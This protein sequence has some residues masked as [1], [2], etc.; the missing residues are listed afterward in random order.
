[1]SEAAK[2]QQGRGAAPTLTPIQGGKNGGGGSGSISRAQRAAVV[3]AMLGENAARPIV[4]KLDDQA[5]AQVS[6]ALETVQYLAREELAEIVIDFLQHLRA[7]SGSFRGG[8]DRA[9]AIVSG[10]LDDQRFGLIFGESPQETAGEDRN[11]TWVQLERQDPKKTAAYLNGLTPNLIALILRK[12]DVSVSSEIVAHLEDEKLDPMIGSLVESDHSDAEVDSVIARMVDIEFLHS[13]QEEDGEE[14]NAHLES[15]GELLSL[16]PSDRRERMMAFLKSEHESK[17]ES[18]EKVIFTIEGLAEMLPR[19]AVPVVFRELGED[20][21]VRLLS[22]LKGSTASV[23]EYLLG[24]ISSRLAD[25]YRDQLKDAKAVTPEET[26]TIQREFLTA[27]MSLKRR[28]LI[29]L[30][31]P[32]A[33]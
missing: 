23:Q 30:E 26:E 33:A 15:I 24:N 13:E 18:I 5:L 8:P 14:D 21:M 20:T 1:M 17:L 22:T 7:Q 19:S 32:P 31:K 4:D 29:T 9:R 16:V 27:L 3:I 6:S 11:S 10:L 12:L 28:G 2:A 25:Q